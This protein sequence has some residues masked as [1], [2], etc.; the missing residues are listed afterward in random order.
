MVYERVTVVPHV[1][2]AVQGLGVGV[3][4]LK[5]QLR[6]EGFDVIV[7]MP[8]VPG[9]AVTVTFCFASIRKVTPKVKGEV[10]AQAVVGVVTEQLAVAV[11][12]DVRLRAQS[13]AEANGA[14]VEA[15]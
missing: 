10:T 14:V 11:G 15:V 9:R 4:P 3:G 5:T 7:T 8:F 6:P 12:E 2:A 13:W 1:K